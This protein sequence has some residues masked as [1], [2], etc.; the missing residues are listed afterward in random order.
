MI[1]RLARIT[2]MLLPKKIRE[3]IYR[4]GW[5]IYKEEVFPSMEASLAILKHWGYY[6][7][8]V[9]DV[10]AY[11][12][13]WTR[14]FKEVF[15]ASKILMI[16]AQA[17]KTYILDDVCIDFQ[18]DVFSE[19][20]L[21]GADHRKEVE[22]IQMKTGSSVFEENSS[23]KRNRKKIPQ[24]TLDSLI[25]QRYKKF[26]PIDFLKLD[27]QGYEIEVLKGAMNLLKHTEF[28]LMEASLI[29]INQGSPLIYEVMSFMEN[30]GFRLLDFCSDSRRNDGA[31]WQTDLLF[32]RS[33]SEFL[34]KPIL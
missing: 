6:P 17:N 18:G 8:N 7:S 32:I 34:P 33:N 28:V 20:A 2:K 1:R 19:I 12:G 16:E 3:L 5:Q 31:L 4:F 25:D 30:H 14:M 21:L 23:I 26:H 13:D 27:V 24:I 9:I 15:P 11:N 22:F 29:P 10:G